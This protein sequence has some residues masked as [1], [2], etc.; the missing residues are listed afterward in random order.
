MTQHQT[1]IEQINLG[2]N[3]QE[4]RLLLK[5]G[6]LDKTEIAVWI[7]R[8]ICKAMWALLHGVQATPIPSSTLTEPN[9]M[10]TADNKAEAIAGFAREA[11]EQKAIENM[12]FKASYVANRE[13]RTDEPLLAIQ[14]MVVSAENTVPQ[15]ELHCKNGQ[16]VKMALNNEL[17]HAITSMMQLATREAAWDLLL[18]TEVVQVNL[19]P[20][21]A[22]L[23]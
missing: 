14:C 2:F 16:V 17:V 4:D 23:H 11:A 7:S 20:S 19:T 13:A 9:K 8:R 12:D 5:L 10:L 6:L 21:S 1:G 18:T 3:E 22:V 15:L